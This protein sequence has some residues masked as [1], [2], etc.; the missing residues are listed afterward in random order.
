MV[1]L[2]VIGRSLLRSS[3]LG[4]VALTAL[5]AIASSA[6]AQD[7]DNDGLS[8]TADPCPSDARNRCA[9]SV[10]I[11]TLTGLPIRLNANVSTNSCSG[12]KVDCTGT[13]WAGDFGFNQSASSATC[14]LN[15]GGTNCVLSG[16][17]ELFGCSNQ[18]T[19]NIFRCEHWDAPA[20]PELIY[21][22]NVPN[23]RYIVNLFFANTYSGTTAVGQRVFDIKVEGQVK[24]TNFDQVAAAGASAK[25]V[26]RAVDV[27]VTD[28][29]GLQ[30]ELVH[31][32]ENPAIKAIE[33]IAVGGCTSN[34][35]CNDGN[36]C[37]TDQCLAGTCQYS[38]NTASCND[39][40]SCTTNDQCNN[41][42]CVGVSNCPSGQTCNAQT[43]VCSAPSVS[44][45]KSS[46]LGQSTSSPTSLQFGPDGKLYVALQNG[47]IHVYTVVKQATNTYAVTNTQVVNLVK[48][49]PNRNDD[50]TLA[51]G[52]TS[53][54]VTGLFVA[55]TAQNPVMYVASADPRIG[56]GSTG[57][58]K[59]L[60]TNS[61][62]ISR[63]TWNGSSWQKLDLVRGLPRS[64]ENHQGNGMY[65]DAATN[66]LYIAYG[67]NTNMGAPSN[68]FVKLPEYALSAAILSINLT[69]IGNTTY[70]L[71]TLDDEDSPNVCTLPAQNFG[72][73]CTTHANCDSSPGAGNGLCTTDVKDPFGG[74]NGKNQARLVPGGP[75]QVYAPGFR[76][77]YDII[78]TTAGKMYTI[79]NGPNAGWGNMPAGEGPGG[80]CT[81]AISEPGVTHKD[82]LHHITGPGYYGGHPNP[83]R[84]NTANKFNASNPQSPVPAGNAVECDY[85][86]P[87]A[88]DGAL[89]T[90]S[91][92]TNGITEYTTNHFGG[93]LQGNLLAASFDNQIW[94]IQL[95][96]TGTA[97]SV[98][99]PLFSSVTP[100]SDPLDVYASKSSDPFPGTIWVASHGS[101]NIIVYEPASLPTCTGA[102]NASLD[103]DGDGYK[104]SDEIANGTNPCS[105]ADMPPDWDKDFISDLNDPDDDNDG[106][107]DTSDKFALDPQNGTTTSFPL[108]YGWENDDPS[109]GGLFG[110]GFTGLM[111][112]G[113]SNYRALFDANNMTA[114]GAA[115]VT[116]VD[117]A[118]EGDALG[119]LNTQ[120]YG[121]Q[122]GVNASSGGANQ[123]T[124]RTRVVGAFLGTTPGD[125][126]SMGLFIGTGD[127]NNYFKVVTAANGGSGGVQT[128]LEIGGIVSTG[129]MLPVTLPGPEG[130][131]LYLTVNRSASTVQAAYAITH[132]G[133]TGP[134]TP[135]GSAVSIPTSWITSANSGL[136]VGLI[137]TSRGPAPPFPA[138]W[139]FIQ[140]SNGAPSCSSNAECNDGN[141]CT[142]DVCSGG[143]CVNNPAA[144]GTGCNDGLACTTGDVCTAGVCAGTPS[145]PLYQAC[146]AGNGTCSTVSGDPDKDGL[147]GSADPCP[148][149]PRNLCFGP[150]AVHGPSSTPIR[151]NA[152]V[153]NAECSGQKTDCNGHVWQADFAFNQ[154]GSA[155]TC[156]LNGGGEACV[157]SGIDTI[158]GCYSE[159]TEDLFQCEHW[160]PAAAPP[161]QYSW[162]VPNGS[163]LVNLFFANTYT[164][165]ATGGSRIFDISIEGVVRYKDFDQIVA[166]GGSGIAVVRSAVVNVTDGN[167]LQ[168]QFLHVV[169]NPSIKAI[170]VL[171][172]TTA[173]SSNAQCNDGNVCNGVETCNPS[174][175]CQPGT[176][177]SCNDGNACNGT[178]TCHP[179]NGC[180]AGTPLVCNDGNACNGLESCVPATGCVAGTPMVCND[181]NSCTVD[182]CQNGTCVFTNTCGPSGNVV[183]DNASVRSTCVGTEGDTITV[184]NVPVGSQP[185]RI[186][187][188]TVG[189][190]EDNADCNLALA[191]ATATYG[192]TF[193]QKAVTALSGTSSWRAC[194]GIFYLVNPP[195][196]TANVVINFP[197]A[198]GTP[199]D[200][201]HAGAFVIYNAAQKAPEAV[202]STGSTAAT[203]TV[204][205]N[206]TPLSVGAIIVDVL[207]RGNTGTFTPTQ[208]ASGQIARWQASCTSSS[209][210]TSTKQATSTSQTALGWSHSSP[211]RFAHALAAF[212]PAGA[213]VPT[214]TTT[215]PAG[216]G[217][218]FV[219]ITPTGGINASTYNANSFN[220][221]ND[222]N[223]SLRITQVRFDLSTAIFPDM[224]FDPVGTAG[225]AAAKCLEANSGA[226]ATGF[227]APSNL[228]TTP[229]S[230]PHD[231]GYDVIDVFFSHFDPG[232]TFGFAV[233]VDPT[234]IRGTSGNGG[235]SS[236]SVSGLEL[237]GATI[238]VYFEDATAIAGKA[239]RTTGSSSGSQNVI[240]AG[241]PPA[242]TISALGITA[243][244]TVTS[245]SQTIRV[246]GPAGASVR[247]LRVE[248][249]LD[250]NGGAGFDLDPF[251]ANNAIVVG[252]TNTTI[253]ANGFVDVPVTL[254]RTSNS[255][256]LNYFAAVIVAPDGSGQ[257]GLVS[258]VVILEYSP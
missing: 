107:P 129:P 229:F 7:T 106:I 249:A 81:N 6:R 21:S 137:S 186:L 58:D 112:N 212:A 65:L 72:L 69:A 177:L 75:V 93:Q 217:R 148:Y 24:Y 135:I 108:L 90:W 215:L 149:D 73:A 199:I 236:G 225:D 84:G 83:T 9:G 39:G 246:S 243:P 228:C 125:F 142:S 14:N 113:S 59:N 248:G 206:I 88:G 254:T 153:S 44:F 124:V 33:V 57:A 239:F 22:F 38:F 42:A 133:T 192:G 180:Q 176:P 219:T 227:V 119:N 141:P 91:T 144:N 237:T 164:S 101:H 158:W 152:N 109:R 195:T 11:D 127:Q 161:L 193:M 197:T 19:Q 36:P 140:I 200:N 201:R 132:L 182:T 51:S 48:N 123:F 235:G 204:N 32:V 95:N 168:L 211:N 196:G 103:E 203:N 138:T 241:P 27:T 100:T 53:R 46:L 70:D 165:T 4:S 256:D 218:A 54:L 49:I 230:G 214:T 60:D 205:T 37:T 172:A 92:S 179:T 96:S 173:C 216:D 45:N 10:A 16:V 222:S 245:A 85:R 146:N 104:N 238:T 166:A 255:S 122:F 26:V 76:N 117:A 207:T 111:T 147:S 126:Q 191:S 121:F 78:K 171:T 23:G 77:A 5:L 253:G 174:L 162:N 251:E 89:W 50:G 234:S 41:G 163:Y 210:A 224:V 169:E 55:G 25:V 15:G 198:T 178:E 233:D 99:Q 134:V 35:Q 194:N 160:D 181:A 114:G 131:D 223:G 220:I 136:A 221:R 79:D 43:G 28:G 12:P 155:A 110:L 189:A 183:I 97:A 252:Q 185:D 257:T 213:F 1:K 31:K 244:A 250:L 86:T 13:A 2:R 247:L 187:I 34:S 20:S 226:A 68:N 8:G 130:V 98:V 52:Q 175:G 232:E 61:G 151:L 40:L 67:G 120:Q 167:G 240:K 66:T 116:T 118:T 145:C 209:S 105:G 159:S 139:D 202:V 208:T 188:V 17:T 128:V 231:N 47:T 82:G 115:G 29:N 80:T 157:I 190:E 184:P 3:L 258:N 62:I 150:V 30:I 74:N 87:G 143:T 56:G 156:N 170:E 94:R 154:S 64:E 102:N 63:L 242:P 18:E 71:P